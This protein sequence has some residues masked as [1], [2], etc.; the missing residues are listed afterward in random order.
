[1]SSKYVVGTIQAALHEFEAFIS[2][3][4]LFWGNL[5]DFWGNKVSLGAEGRIGCKERRRLLLFKMA[6]PSHKTLNL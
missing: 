4:Y 2:E 1:M 3:A 6:L 5:M